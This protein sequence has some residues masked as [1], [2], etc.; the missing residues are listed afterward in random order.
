MTTLKI[1]KEDAS[2]TTAVM[3]LRDALPMDVI[4]KDIIG[5]KKALEEEERRRNYLITLIKAAYG[6]GCNVEDH[7][8]EDLTPH[9]VWCI[10][11]QRRV[12][13]ELDMFD[14]T[15]YELQ[16]FQLHV[17]FYDSAEE[18][19]WEFYYGDCIELLPKEVY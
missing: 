17:D 4:F 7:M 16:Q 19:S 13:G 18:G 1:Q 8:N 9:E 12:N 10:R 5:K 14:L 3:C 2:C 15:E 6:E 11:H